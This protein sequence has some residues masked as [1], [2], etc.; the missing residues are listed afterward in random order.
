LYNYG[1]R[2]YNA[3]TARFTTVDPIRDGDNWFVYVGNNP[4]NFIDPFGLAPGDLF[5]TTEDAAND[6][7]KTY[8]DDSIRNDK[9]YAASIYKTTSGEYYYSTPN[10]G[11]AH[12]ANAGTPPLDSTDIKVGYVHS[13]GDES[14]GYD[15]ENF[16]GT[17]GSDASGDIGLAERT[18]RE[19]YV[20]T[21][22]GQVKKYDP[23]TDS[24]SILPVDNSIPS[25]P[26]AGT[27]RVTSTDAS[28]GDNNNYI[29]PITG[30]EVVFEQSKKSTDCN[31]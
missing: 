26:D 3:S 14:P 15:D 2:D 7:A 16:S 25:T 21:P 11:D 10:Q 6:F 29:D 8:N 1:F 31:R 13:H 27:D 12:S 20:V 9:E 30:L 5:A 18:G 24:T 22:G 19:M 28:A 4:I 23:D 17:P